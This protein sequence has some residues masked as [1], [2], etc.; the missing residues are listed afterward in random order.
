MSSKWTD[1]VRYGIGLRL[2]LWYAA[3]F[4]ISAATLSV[5]TYVVLA[6]ALAAEDHSVLESMLS[7]YAGEYEREGLGGLQQLIDDDA[8]E[9]LHERL[10]VRVVNGQQDLVYYATPPGWGAVDLSVLDQAASQH[11][12]WITLDNAPDK[13]TLEI[14]T[15]DLRDGVVVQV[16]RSSRTR[17]ELLDNYRARAFE[18]MGLIAVVAA[19]GGGLLTNVGLAPLRAFDA[20]LQSILRTGR[21]DSRV[22]TRGS[23]DPLDQLGTRVNEMLGRIQTLL[24]GMRGALDNVAHDLRT[25]LTRFRNVAEEAMIGGDP[26]AAREGLA[27]AL[28]EASH[29]NATLTALMDISEAETGTMKL[30]PERFQLAALAQE[31]I[32]LFL[33]EAD[34]K[35]I[36]IQSTIPPDIELT[37]D[38]TR[39]RQVLANLIENAVKYTNPGGR[40][41]VG[42]TPQGRE[43]VLTVRDTGIGISDT[44]L[45]FIWDRLYRGDASRSARGLGLGLSLVKAIVE[46]HGGRVDVTSSPRAG[47]VFSVVIPSS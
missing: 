7:R 16:G 11:A 30:V 47:S 32:A 19:I 14:G 42:A 26:A 37:A 20:T 12:D 8:G 6:R 17:D 21:F 43:V 39:L 36:T 3:L 46:A 10:L 1:Y 31:A 4:I 23:G 41:E 27:A 25:P 33:D 15:L 28:E 2:G 35:G 45:P 24:A 38:R 34:E 22:E 40:V 44:D 9:G 5:F 13:T 18:I 29:V